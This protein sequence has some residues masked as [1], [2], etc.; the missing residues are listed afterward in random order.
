MFENSTTIWMR[1]G[2]WVVELPLRS[3]VESCCVGTWC[4]TSP[5]WCGEVSPGKDVMMELP[6][7]HVG[8]ASCARD[9][10]HLGRQGWL[11][12]QFTSIGSLLSP[13]SCGPLGAPPVD[14]L[15][16]Y[17]CHI[18]SCLCR[19]ALLDHSI[20]HYCKEKLTSSFFPPCKA[21]DRWPD[22]LQV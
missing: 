7:L 20:S 21:E 8:V 5:S 22:M 17:M 12:N 15:E 6:V 19:E 10:N 13:C 11:M 14:Y 3:V 1:T 9:V 4:W 18:L 2:W 16:L